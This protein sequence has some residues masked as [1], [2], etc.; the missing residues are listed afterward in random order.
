MKIFNLIYKVDDDKYPARTLNYHIPAEDLDT[1]Q[2]VVKRD[3]VPNTI[4]QFKDLKLTLVSDVTHTQGYLL[5]EEYR[6]R[7][8]KLL[9]L[10]NDGKEVYVFTDGVLK[11]FKV[12]GYIVQD[13]GDSALL[14]KD[15]SSYTCNNIMEHIFTDKSTALEYLQQH[16]NKVFSDMRDVGILS[17]FKLIME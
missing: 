12:L 9:E 16:Y 1:A 6:K 7:I 5:Y 17:I 3:I 11:E 14:K 8:D 10:Y 2:E 4:Y 13:G 15:K